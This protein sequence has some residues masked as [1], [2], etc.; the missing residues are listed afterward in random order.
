[1]GDKV[2]QDCKLYYD[3]TPLSSAD[4]SGADWN[5]IDEAKDVTVNLEASEADASTRGGIFK[6]YRAA[7]LDGSIDFDIL[8]D[9][10]KEAYEALRDAYV[11]RLPIA[12]A[13]MDGAIATVGSEGLAGN[14][15]VTGFNRNEPLEESVTV[16]VTVKPHSYV[17]WY[18]LKSGA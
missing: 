7:M 16:T 13:A 17:D 8:Y 14:F 4:P 11:G 18:E 9:A 5:E 6:A 2:G 10:A 1:M 12:L 15:I 3:A